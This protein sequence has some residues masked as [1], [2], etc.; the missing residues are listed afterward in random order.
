[1][2][3]YLRIAKDTGAKIDNEAQAPYLPFFVSE[4]F[5]FYEKISTQWIVGGFMSGVPI[6]LNY[7]SV[8]IVADIYDF[9]LTSWQME[10][11]RDIEK[12]YLRSF[13]K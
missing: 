9:S 10:G 1:M 4:I 2:Q 8:R 6:G 7:Q 3:E 11:L 12:R 5:W 13:Q